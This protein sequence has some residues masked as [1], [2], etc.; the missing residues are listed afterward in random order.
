MGTLCTFLN[1]T[2]NLVGIF[3]FK[4]LRMLKEIFGVAQSMRLRFQCEALSGKDLSLEQA[5]CSNLSLLCAFEIEALKPLKATA[6]LP[7]VVGAI[8]SSFDIGKPFTTCCPS[9]TLT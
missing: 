5:A 1:G 6:H 3:S 8:Y 4:I 2:F 9:A 7:F